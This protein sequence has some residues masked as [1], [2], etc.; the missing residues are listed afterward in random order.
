MPMPIS[1][2]TTT[3]IMAGVQS[4]TAI[5]TQAIGGAQANKAARDEQ[6]FKLDSSKEQNRAAAV[7]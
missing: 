3:L 4:V 6:T 1:D 5:A 2:P 7:K